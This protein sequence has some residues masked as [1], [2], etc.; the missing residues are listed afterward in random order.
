MAGVK[1]SVLDIDNPAYDCPSGCALLALQRYA[2]CWGQLSEIRVD[3]EDP[4]SE[5]YFHNLIVD[6]S[7]P[8]RA[9]GMRYFAKLTPPAASCT[10]SGSVDVDWN[11]LTKDPA[12]G[13][14]VQAHCRQH[15]GQLP[16]L[17]QRKF[18]VRWDE[19]SAGAIESWFDMDLHR[20]RPDPKAKAGDTVPCN[21]GGNVLG[22]ATIPIRSL[23]LG[24]RANSGLVT[25]S[26]RSDRLRRRPGSTGSFTLS[27]RRRTRE[28]RARPSR[29]FPSSA[30]REPCTLASTAFSARPTARATRTA[31]TATSTRRAP[32]TASRSTASPAAARR[33]GHD[34]VMFANGCKPFYDTNYL[35]RPRMVELHHQ[36]VPGQAERNGAQPHCALVTQRPPKTAPLR[37]EGSRI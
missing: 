36:G 20:S 28:A 24:N 9:P 15:D 10:Y 18:R 17:R 5:P 34:F 31:T 8:D 6:G 2:D 33:S 22:G 12:T 14:T 16:R 23:F 11:G 26:K 30:S 29:S 19:Q 27:M 21:E 32:A 4:K 13:E 1:K 35:H 3:K 37:R 7:G 25:L